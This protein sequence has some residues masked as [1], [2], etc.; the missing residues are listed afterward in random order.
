MILWIAN[1][2]GGLCII[3]L[4]FLIWII[5]KKHIQQLSAFLI[6]IKILHPVWLD[7]NSGTGLAFQFNSEC[8]TTPLEVIVVEAHYHILVVFNSVTA[9]EPETRQHR[10]T[11]WHHPYRKVSHS[12]LWVSGKPRRT[13]FLLNV[14]T[15]IAGFRWALT[16]V[17]C[18]SHNA[19]WNG[20]GWYLKYFPLYLFTLATLKS[21]WRS[22]F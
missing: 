8:C 14:I 2:W 11:A 4:H 21:A 19:L 22:L 15:T 18:Q 6:W 9:E 12:C 16:P 13:D 3:K 20:V 10:N 17:L 7:L 5:T 1:I